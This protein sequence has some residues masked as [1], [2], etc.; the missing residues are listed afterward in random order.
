I[1]QLGFVQLDSIQW[2]ERAHHMTLFARNQTYRPHH[3]GPLIDRDQ[4]LFENWTHDASF[5]PTC[6]Y[7]YWRHKFKRDEAKLKEKFE[8]WQGA[9]FVDHIDGLLERITQDGPLMSRDLDRDAG[10]REMWQWH[11]GK[12]AL[13]YLWRTGRLATRARQNFQKVYDLPHHCLSAD[14]HGRKV[15]HTDF[16]DW[17]CR[18]ALDRLGFGAAADIARFWD[19]LS[20]AEVR[21]WLA[22]QGG[23]TIREIEITGRDKTVKNLIARPDIED[24]VDTLPKLPERVRALSP[25]DP[26]IRD[27]KRLLWLWGF[28]YRIEIYVP[29]E[30]RLWGYYVFPLL[31]GNKLIGRIDMKANRKD[32]VLEVRKLWLETGVKLSESRRSGI[33][34]ELVRQSRLCGVKGIHWDGNVVRQTTHPVRRQLT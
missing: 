28:D 34:S 33:M 4:L 31:E 22:E 19:L 11:D 5:I 3:L 23:Q 27:R 9:G 18:S 10:K 8:Q 7:P 15:E 1:E 20:I 17:A 12:A 2:V 30:K 24:V 21:A 16:V 13:E 26:V 6:F 25:F 14:D 29:A 32:G